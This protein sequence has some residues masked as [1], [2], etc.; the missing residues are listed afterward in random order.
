MLCCRPPPYSQCQQIG[1]KKKPKN[2]VKSPSLSLYFHLRP[3]RRMK[4]DDGFL[5]LWT[6]SSRGLQR[7]TV[8]KYSPKNRKKTL[9]RPEYSYFFTTAPQSSASPSHL[10]Q[11]SPRQTR[12]EKRHWYLLDRHLF[13]A[14]LQWILFKMIN[15]VQD[16]PNAF[17]SLLLCITELS[18]TVVPWLLIVIIPRQISPC[19]WPCRRPRRRPVRFCSEKYHCFSSTLFIS[20]VL[21]STSVEDCDFRR[22][23]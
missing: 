4:I 10:S 18:S 1:A 11:R 5:P 20:H 7:S 9:I 16:V 22:W 12:S 23:D 17:H 6:T 14:F 15:S 13:R 2:T 8:A 21:S 19:P 3:S